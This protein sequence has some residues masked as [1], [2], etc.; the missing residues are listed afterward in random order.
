MT[1]PRNDKP[2][3]K[4]NVSLFAVFRVIIA[5][6]H[7][8]ANDLRQTVRHQLGLISPQTPISLI[9]AN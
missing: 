4:A 5:S 9:A 3:G 6:R 7:P 8:I 2:S 1:S